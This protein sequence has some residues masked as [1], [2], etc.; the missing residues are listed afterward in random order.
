V[1]SAIEELAARAAPQHVRAPLA[2]QGLRGKLC[3]QNSSMS[4]V[5]RVC[6][7]PNKEYKSGQIWFEVGGGKPMLYID[8]AR[9]FR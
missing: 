7:S 5:C 4:Q 2:E 6:N 1:L 8:K 9:V 3:E